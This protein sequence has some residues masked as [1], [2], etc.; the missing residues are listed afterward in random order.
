M[1]K[2]IDKSS[3]SFSVIMPLKTKLQLLTWLSFS[4][5]L[6]LSFETLTKHNNYNQ[7]WKAI[8]NAITHQQ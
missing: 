8:Y 2:L 3:L 6:I 5:Q 1:G 4:Y 7:E